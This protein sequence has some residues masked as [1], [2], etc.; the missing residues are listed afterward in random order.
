MVVDTIRIIIVAQN[1]MSASYQINA[2]T[3]TSYAVLLFL[4][5]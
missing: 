2:C 5:I 3:W 4:E 1:I